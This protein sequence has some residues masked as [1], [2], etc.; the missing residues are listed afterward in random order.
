MFHTLIGTVT[1]RR[2]VMHR[3]IGLRKRLLGTDDLRVYDLYVPLSTARPPHFS[4]DEACET[5]IAG[6]TPLGQD[7]VDA[8]RKGLSGDWVDVFE[9]RGKRSGAYSWAPT[10]CTRSC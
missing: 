8:L 6:L 1:E 9:C 5:L 4:Y 2:D 3:Y 10:A 7:Y